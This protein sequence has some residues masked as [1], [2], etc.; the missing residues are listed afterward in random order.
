MA[1]KTKMKAAE[2]MRT[3]VESIEKPRNRDTTT[4]LMKEIIESVPPIFSPFLESGFIIFFF[5]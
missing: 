5:K 3:A 4:A 1:P 2:N